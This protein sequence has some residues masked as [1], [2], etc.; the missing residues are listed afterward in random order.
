MPTDSQY[1]AA[2]RREA[3]QILSR[4]PYTHVTHSPPR[5]LA[6]V[7]HAI[8]RA[9][10]VVFGPVVR[11]FV[12]H[13]FQPIGHGFVDVFGSWAGLVGILLAVV[14]GALLA[15]VLIRRRSRVG[16]EEAAS[17]VEAASLDP[18]VLEAEAERLAA[19]GDFGGAVRLRFEAGLYRLESA[20]ILADQ[21]VRT[22]IE[23]AAVI[24]SPTFETLAEQHQAIAYAAAG[25]GAGDVEQARQGWPLV[26][27]EARRH[28]ALVESAHQ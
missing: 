22:D 17:V 25:A 8:G 11:W 4:S 20:G 27:A 7:L 18:S 23:L 3:R 24:G 15:T 5:P 6:G 9:I 1:A 21:R 19:A 28:R 14:G 10:S 16:A 2:A 12:H 26:P 13:L